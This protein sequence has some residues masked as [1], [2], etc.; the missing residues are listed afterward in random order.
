MRH[1]AT[2]FLFLCYFLF[3]FLLVNAQLNSNR[4]NIIFILADDLGIGDVSCFNPK[5]KINTPNIDK[6]GNNGIIFTDAHSSSAVCTPTRYGILTGRYNWRSRLK[7]GVLVQYDKPL[8]EIGRTNMAT[9]LK[10]KG[11]QTAAMG[12][13]HLGWN[14]PTIDGKAPV[15]NKDQQNLDFAKQVS[16]GPTSIG[17]DYFFG[18][19]APNYPPYAYMENDRVLGK[20][21]VFY[22][23]HPYADCRP[24]TGV[25]GWNLENIMPDLQQR[26]VNYI[27]NAASTGKP[28]FLYLPITAPHTPIS[29][30]RLFVGSSGL[31][32]YADFVK[33]VDD[34]VGSIQQA[35]AANNLTQNT[36]LVFTSDN[37]CSPQADFKFL[38]ER[39][40][41]SNN[42]YRGHKADIFEAGHRVP[43]LM[44][45]PATIKRPSTVSQ[46]VSLNDF[47]ATFASIVGYDLKDNEAEDSYNL[48][49]A[50]LKPSV[51]KPIR[52]A[53]VHHSING[54]FAI[55]KG[56]WK[57]IL[58]AGSGGWSFPTP[59][60]AEE[61]LPPIQLY[62]LKKDPAEKDNCYHQF[63][64]QVEEL[65]ALL[66]KYIQEGRSTPG[67]PQKN[68]GEY[69]WKQLDFLK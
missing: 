66:K 18:M 12:K 41:D 46:T 62:N 43:L 65:T 59:G 21:T 49:P 24:G 53:T 4:P 64:Q 35:L 40:H 36:I 31:N 20:P 57:L 39:G 11:Y 3:A 68:D 69:P 16:G 19:D 30:D 22:P 63:P 2:S 54:S 26:S 55:R 48:L 6:I 29:P 10:S 5:G 28:F 1:H 23:T 13:W 33:Q 27:G 51:N 32:V 25:E 67:K 34:F 14:W 42:G 38:K 17:F 8:L 47:M 56:D 58:A 37:G 52:E 7:Q 60:K 44:Q 9:M 15:D 61:G 50:L 45:W